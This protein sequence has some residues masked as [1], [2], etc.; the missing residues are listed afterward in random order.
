MIFILGILNYLTKLSLSFL[1]NCRK[2]G[3]KFTVGIFFYN[4]VY[5]AILFFFCL[6]HI[7]YSFYSIKYAY[8]IGPTYTYTIDI[9]SMTKNVLLYNTVIKLK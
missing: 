3:Y 5:V 2:K 9:L 1:S 7:M 4:I 8:F 6:Q